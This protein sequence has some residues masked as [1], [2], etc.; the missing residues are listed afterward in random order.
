MLERS[1]W[2]AGALV[3]KEIRCYIDPRRLPPLLSSRITPAQG[4]L[5]RLENVLQFHRFGQLA[6]L[7]HR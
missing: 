3:V 7:F 6:L 4:A 1:P 2:S 5:D